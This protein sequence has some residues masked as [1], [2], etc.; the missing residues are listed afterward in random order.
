MTDGP[1]DERGCW[2]QH[3]GRA[4]HM[5]ALHWAQCA[6]V[7][8]HTSLALYTSAFVGVY[9][10]MCVCIGA[11][12]HVLMFVP[13]RGASVYLGHFLGVERSQRERFSTCYPSILL[14]SRQLL[15]S[16]FILT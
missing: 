16:I 14:S 10:G 2:V 3:C 11:S 6:H 13:W 9:I 12:V 8:V 4:E 5:T 1:K 7:P 15:L